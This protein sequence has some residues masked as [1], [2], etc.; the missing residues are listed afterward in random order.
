MNKAII[1]ESYGSMLA[2]LYPN[3]LEIQPLNVTFQ[4]TDDCNLRCSYCYQINKGHHKM[5]LETA[6]A[7]IDLLFDNSETTKMLDYGFNTYQ[8]D[9][10]VSDGEIIG[11]EKVLLGKADYVEIVPKQSVNILNSKLGNKRKVT[12]NVDINQIK[13]PV[14]VGDI[15]G[16]ITVLENG[17]VIME[18]D[19][20]VL[21]NVD[22]ANILKVYYKNLI[23]MLKGTI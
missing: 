7:F 14:K 3:D 1:D 13:A 22:K 9:T 6:K 17:N 16:K 23:D 21:N 18:V 12:Y 11:K 10:L 5:P 20:T 15:V 8:I 2:R 4:V 19:A